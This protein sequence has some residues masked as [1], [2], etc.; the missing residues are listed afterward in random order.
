MKKI[1][2]TNHLAPILSGLIALTIILSVFSFSASA[3]AAGVTGSPGDK[4]ATC[5]N[6]HSGTAMTQD[7]IKTNIPA[8]GYK[9]GETYEI[10]FTVSSAGMKDFGFQLTVEDANDNNVGTFV[11]TAATTLQNADAYI[12]H[13]RSS[14]AGNNGTKTWKFNWTAPQKTV[15]D[16]TFYGAGNAS[17]GNRGT[18]GDFVFTDKKVV[19]AFEQ[20]QKP[21]NTSVA[22]ISRPEV[23]RIYPNPAHENVWFKVEKATQV[24][25]INLKGEQVKVLD[26]VV[27]EN[28]IDLSELDFGV[29]HVISTDGTINRSLVKM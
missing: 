2:L 7:M 17:N 26:L 10:E 22:T 18:S 9:V 1:N 12:T 20:P 4:G 6:C 16:V 3:P 24:Q 13:T 23:L 15:G 28:N 8:E 14:I 5:T 27:G 11:G 25:L 19:K 21:I 29:Y